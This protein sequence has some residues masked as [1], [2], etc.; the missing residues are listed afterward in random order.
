MIKQGFGSLEGRFEKAQTDAELRFLEQD[1]KM[2][3]LKNELHK[4]ENRLLEKKAKK[5]RFI[6]GVQ[7]VL[8]GCG[9]T[10]FGILISFLSFMYRHNIIN[11]FK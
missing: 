7:L 11:V 6:A 10:T 1:N 8:V 9:F 2:F 3:E 5:S 4:L